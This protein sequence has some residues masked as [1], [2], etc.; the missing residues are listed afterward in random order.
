MNR[1]RIPD[2]V[3]YEL[4]GRAAGRC[5]FRGCHKLVYLDEVTMSASN[6]G[7]VSHIVAASPTGPRGDPKRSPELQ[8]DIG[9]LMLT[10]RDH[11]KVID[12]PG[13]VEEYPEHLL[14]TFKREHERRI[15]LVTGVGPEAKVHVVIVRMA[16][17]GRSS[18]I[19]SDEA[20]RAL[21]PLFPAEEQPRLIDLSQL[22]LSPTTPGYLQLAADALDS[23]LVTQRLLS[24][25]EFPNV[26]LFALAPIPVLSFLGWRMGQL[27]RLHLFQ[28]HPDTE[29]W[30]WPAREE[31]LSDFFSIH[32]PDDAARD[33][34]REIALVLSTSSSVGHDRVRE[35]LADPLIYEIRA[36]EPG[37][38]FLRSPTRLEMFGVKLREVLETLRSRHSIDRPIHVF[39]A[40]QA[41]FAIEFG[42]NLRENDAAFVVH[43]YD[44]AN[45]KYEGSLVVNQRGGG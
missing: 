43:E 29:S 1:R 21:L 15:R 27:R 19:T 34:G 45:R 8:T 12:D 36:E 38:D 4:W 5:Q 31:A 28:R 9:N 18:A 2:R 25:A 37:R 24:V 44:D 16:V 13:R 7:W 30:R 35:I 39:A 3:R 40:V 23:Q 11:G 32:V 42:R 10:C 41:P 14:L 26:A 22:T 20:H 6:L 33:D 17:R